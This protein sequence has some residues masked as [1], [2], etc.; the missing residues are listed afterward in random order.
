MAAAEANGNGFCAGIITSRRRSQAGDIIAAARRTS[1]SESCSPKAE[2]LQEFGVEG[3]SEKRD[4]DALVDGLLATYSDNGSCH[5]LLTLHTYCSL[6]TLLTTHAAW[7]P[8]C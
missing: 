8:Q 7:S 1:K 3:M 5:L 2:L 4:D 6:L